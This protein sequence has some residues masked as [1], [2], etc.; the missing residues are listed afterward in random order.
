MEATALC[1]RLMVLELILV[2]TQAQ[3]HTQS[4]SDAV[5]LR[6]T[7]DRL[8]HFEYE[9]VSFHCE[10]T[11]GSTQLKGIRNTE[12]FKP[13]C[14]IKRTPMGSSC[15]IDK[16]YSG[17]SGEYWCETDGGERSYSANITVAAGP[18]I[19][20]TPALPVLVGQNVVLRCRHKTTSTNTKAHFYKDDVLME[21]S[22]ADEMPINNVSKSDEGVYKCI[23][24]G[25]GASPGSWLA[26]RANTI[27]IISPSPPEETLPKATAAPKVLIL[28]WVVVTILT[29]GLLVVGFHH[30]R[31]HRVVLCFS[32]K[33]ATAASNSG[34]DDEIVSEDDAADDPN[35]VTYAV[36]VT[37]QRKDKDTE[38]AD[39]LSLCL[40]TNRSRKPQRQ[41]DE[42]ESS[43][44]PVYSALTIRANPRTHRPESEAMNRTAAKDSS[45]TEQEVIYSPIKKSTKSS[46]T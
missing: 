24:P 5:F 4:V 26:V 42:D 20:E 19:L 32:S 2:E 45:L 9:S 22:P 43:H 18:V 39:N 33:M 46:D 25:V 6:I 41:K 3:N 1:F 36:V 40:K 37:K 21:R 23:I 44:Q 31:K 38:D 30:I 14:D 34:K 8:Q 7:P 10:G 11:D 13:V 29:L 16:S 17:D 27:S 15:T 35:S 28:L 12:E